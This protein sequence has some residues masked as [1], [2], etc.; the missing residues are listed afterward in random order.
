MKFKIKINKGKWKTLVKCPFCH[1]NMMINELS[2]TDINYIDFPVYNYLTNQT[3]GTLFCPC[4]KVKL[5][6]ELIKEDEVI[7]MK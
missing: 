7:L 5:S 3:V 6:F 4:R 1:E 2:R